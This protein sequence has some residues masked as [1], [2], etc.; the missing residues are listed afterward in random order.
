MD[1]SMEARDES[2]QN[3]APELSLVPIDYFL[4][5]PHAKGQLKEQLTQV[6]CKVDL[7]RRDVSLTA[8]HDPKDPKAWA[9]YHAN[10]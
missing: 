2:P 5:L 8:V 6:A 9:N 10:V 7:Y 3:H 4:L 1:E